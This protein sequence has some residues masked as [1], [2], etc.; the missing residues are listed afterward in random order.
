MGINVTLEK[1]YDKFLKES[2]SEEI[3]VDNVDLM[4][5]NYSVS[6]NEYDFKIYYYPFNC[7]G[8]TSQADN[9]IIKYTERKG[10]NRFYWKVQD[11][12]SIRDYICL[13]NRTDVNVCELIKEISIQYPFVD[14]EEIKKLSKMKITNADNSNYSSLYILGFKNST[15]LGGQTVGIEWI[16][17]KCPDPD[18]IGY[19]YNYDDNYFDSFLVKH[20][21]KYFL[22]IRKKISL[23]N[24]SNLHYWVFAID[25]AKDKSKYKIYLKG[26]EC[27][28]L[29]PGT[30]ILKSI[31]PEINIKVIE[32]IDNFSKKHTELFLYGFAVCVDTEEKWSVNF[33]FKPSLAR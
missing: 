19:N 11:T 24:N 25:Y 27:R 6:A 13:Y 3:T 15:I 10:M 2:N 16:T 17:R 26:D 32:E 4:G 18:D 12:K 29:A 7:I 22:D 30:N 14:L 28:T 9:A 8:C 31:F 33:Y 5:I 20:N 1:L 21:N 23:L